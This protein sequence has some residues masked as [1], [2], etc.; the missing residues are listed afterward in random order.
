[1]GRTT[2]LAADFWVD[3]EGVRI[4]GLDWGGAAGGTPLIM[5]HGVGGNAMAFNM[6]GP[7]LVAA[8]GDAYRV[9]S[10]DQRGGGDSDKPAAGYEQEFFGRDVLAVQQAMGGGPAVLVGHS[11]GGWLAPYIAGTWPARVRSLVLIDPARMTYESPQAQEAFY[12][13]V[14]AGLGPFASEQAALDHAV[15]STPDAYWGPERQASVLAG[16]YRAFDGTVFGKMPRRVLDE[17]E[18]VRGDDVLR[19]LT[20]SIDVPTLLFVSS[21]SDAH[22]QGQ[23]LEYA[24]RIAGTTVVMLDGTHSLQ[25]DC[26]DDVA[27]RVVEHLRA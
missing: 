11:R 7:R 27:A 17:L 22:R 15:A 5:L 1:V 9:V 20:S 23:K 26:A 16:L 19:P 12:S 2:E 18:R 10:I 3:S 4:H 14:R 8:V 21:R 25:H 24:E 13:R 6:L